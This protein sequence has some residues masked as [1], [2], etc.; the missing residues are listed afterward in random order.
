M[1]LIFKSHANLPNETANNENEYSFAKMIFHKRYWNVID[2]NEILFSGN[3][4]Q[5]VYI[6]RFFTNNILIKIRDIPKSEYYVCVIPTYSGP[7]YPHIPG[8]FHSEYLRMCEYWG[9]G[10]QYSEA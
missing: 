4:G 8:I 1:L 2:E 5:K 6:A 3:E 7:E 9:Y 10:N